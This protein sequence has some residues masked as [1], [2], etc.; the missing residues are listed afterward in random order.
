MIKYNNNISNPWDRIKND[1]QFKYVIYQMGQTQ[2][3][4]GFTQVYSLHL[5]IIILQL[6]NHPNPVR[7]LEVAAIIKTVQVRGAVAWLLKLQFK[8]LS[9]AVLT[10]DYYNI[11]LKILPILQ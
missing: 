7:I 2:N 6:I 8:M 11:T 3:S 1:I 9:P 5:N 10:R 4:C